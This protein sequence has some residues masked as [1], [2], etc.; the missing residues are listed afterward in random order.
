MFQNKRNKKNYDLQKIID[1]EK[2]KNLLSI[3]LYYK[4]GGK[5]WQLL[6]YK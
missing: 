6:W 3:C 4:M 1:D 2:I 5:K